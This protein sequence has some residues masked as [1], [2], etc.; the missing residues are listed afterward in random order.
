MPLCFDLDGTLGHFSSG[1]VLLREALGDLWGQAPTAEELGRCQGSTDWEIVGELHR[2]RFGRPL[3][4]AAYAAYDTACV[5]RFRTAFGPGGREAIPHLGVVEAMHRLAARHPVWLVSGNAPDL[6]A[7]KAEVL[8]ID[9]TIPRL[10]SLPGH[11]RIT[12]LRHALRDCPAASPCSV[13]PCGTAPAPTCTSGTVPTTSPPPRP[14]ASPSWASATP[15]PATTP[16]CPPTRRR[17]GWSRPS[18]AG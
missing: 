7:F 5:G 16:A 9:P 6:L 1:F 4:E 14:R 17:S 12:L 3:E 15:C 8:G 10:G 18:S 13:T 2:M 11:D